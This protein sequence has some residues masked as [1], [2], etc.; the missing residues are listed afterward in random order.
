MR[1]RRHTKSEKEDSWQNGVIIEVSGETE[2]ELERNVQKVKRYFLKH[3]PDLRPEE[4]AESPDL[5]QQ[6]PR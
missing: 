6:L 4:I 2:E 3:I 1:T 5:K